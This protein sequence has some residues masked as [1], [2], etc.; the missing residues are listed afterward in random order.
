VAESHLLPN[1]KKIKMENIFPLAENAPEELTPNGVCP[2]LGEE[3]WI[4]AQGRFNPCCAPDKERL[5]L[6]EFGNLSEKKFLDI[7]NSP[8]YQKLVQTYSNHP[9]CLKCNMR[10]PPCKGETK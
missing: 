4:S 5:G 2:F 9:L 3:A 8:A 10:R 7:W 6:G 1:G